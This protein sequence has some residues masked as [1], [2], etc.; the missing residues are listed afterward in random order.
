MIL[1]VTHIEETR[2][3]DEQVPLRPGNSHKAT[4]FRIISNRQ[5]HYFKPPT[6]GERHVIR[7]VEKVGFEPR[8]LGYQALRS[9][10]C[11]TSPVPIRRYI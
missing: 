6:A 10:N 2:D 7:F 11:A 3:A 5:R 4:I 9:A 8:I 1:R